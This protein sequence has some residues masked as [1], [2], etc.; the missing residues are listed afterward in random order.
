MRVSSKPLD[1]QQMTMLLIFGELCIR[2]AGDE[3]KYVDNCNIKCATFCTCLPN[4]SSLVCCRTDSSLL[5]LQ[6]GK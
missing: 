4:C 2:V 3:R 6:V 5:L 1:I